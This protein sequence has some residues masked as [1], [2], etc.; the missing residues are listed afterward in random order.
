MSNNKFFEMT[1]PVCGKYYFSDDTETEKSDPEYKG[2]ELDQCTECGWIYD[3][4][5]AENPDLKN[6][7][8]ELSVNDY[9]KIYLK[10]IADN[11][12]YSYLDDNY[13][14]NPHL[15]PVCGKHTFSDSNSFE[16]CPVC[17]WTDDSVMEE[18]PDK[19]AGNSND[20]CL[21]DFRK[22]YL[23]K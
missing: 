8:N 10:K 16:I 9:K 1:C 3:V 5:Q 22:R 12:N 20:L 21:N 6:G 23:Q 15:C 17:G 13:I 18:E 19:W 2:K 4:S 14:P 11:P 7:A